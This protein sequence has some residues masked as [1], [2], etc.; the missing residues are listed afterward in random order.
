FG[1]L[2]GIAA[3][4]V[5]LVKRHGLIQPPEIIERVAS[6]RPP[7]G[8]N[9]RAVRTHL[10][11]IAAVGADRP[12]GVAPLLIATDKRKPAA[13][14]RPVDVPDRPGHALE[15]HASLLPPVSSQEP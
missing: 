11:L 10:L 15:R 4:H 1:L 3:R 8:R 13:R 7:H 6:R 14:R 12:D 2:P 9:L 5:N